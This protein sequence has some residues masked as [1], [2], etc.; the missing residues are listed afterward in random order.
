[1]LIRAEEERDWAAV[2]TVNGSAFEASTEA[3]L[4]ALLRERAQPVLSLI[5][6]D[7]GA[8]VGH[9]IFSPVLLSGHAHLKILGLGPMAV[10]PRHQRKGIGSALVR[11]DLEQGKQLGFGAVVLVGHPQYY[12]RF[13]FQP[14]ARFNIACEFDVPEEAFMILELQPGFLAGAQ[15]TIKYH[16][17][18]REGEVG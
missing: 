9:I 11:A 14:A 15:G 1:M 12:P 8:I 5:A 2:D 18:F 3:R 17:A 6:E 13:G 16:P 10:L 4:V 7:D